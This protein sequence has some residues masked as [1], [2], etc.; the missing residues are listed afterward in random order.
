MK[1][2]KFAFPNKEWV[3]RNEETATFSSP[4]T[5][6][7]QSMFLDYQVKNGS[8]SA[9]ITAIE[10]QWNKD[11]GYEFQECA[12]MFR[13][14]DGDHFYV[15]G[16][17]GF[18]QKFYIAKCSDAHS[19]WQLLKAAGS[20]HDLEKGKPN[21][22]RVQFQ[23]NRITLFSEG[24][25]MINATDD[26]YSSGR[27]GLRTNRTKGRFANV[28]IT[29]DKPRC[30]VI[31][32]FDPKMKS[33]YEIIVETAKRHNVECDRAD[34][35]YISQPIVEEVKD[36]IDSADLVII[37]V[38]GQNANVYFEAGIASALLKKWII[39]SQSKDDIAFDIKHFRV[40]IYQ[41][42]IGHEQH[43]RDSLS[44]AIEET[45]AVSSQSTLS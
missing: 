19:P 24:A 8:M 29:P 37:D 7:D 1:P 14:V 28:D 27:C 18:A 21:N 22:L 2:Q 13:H 16:L 20:A 23:G 31:M 41:D 12:F 6:T 39:L 3:D 36:R 4:S 15:A 33:I 26:S 34:K 40:I 10:G 38:T 44:R 43:F 32:P 45:L 9:S 11:L 25:E 30:F 5:D 42:K 17:G 35:H